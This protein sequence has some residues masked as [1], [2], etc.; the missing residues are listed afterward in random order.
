[1][2]PIETIQ[3]AFLQLTFAIKL[4]NY[5]EVGK[6]SKSDFDTDTLILLKK[7]NISFPSGTFQS[8]NDIILAAENNFTI[9]FGFSA[10][11]LNQALS[12]A[13]F[14]SEELVPISKFDFC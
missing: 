8:D 7:R 11:A 12:D 5:V 1:M 2:Q 13:G 14:P 6:V 4:L 10:I 9:T 3:H